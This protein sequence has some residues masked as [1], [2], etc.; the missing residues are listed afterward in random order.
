MS[1]F[2]LAFVCIIVGFVAG[3]LASVR[4][5]KR[6][7]DSLPTDYQHFLYGA[8]HDYPLNGKRPSDFQEQKPF[9]GSLGV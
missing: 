8:L 5:M 3:K 2:L 7:A 4:R 1:Y 6:W 9:E